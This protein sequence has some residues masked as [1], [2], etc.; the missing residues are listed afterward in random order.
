[1]NPLIKVQYDNGATIEYTFDAV[2]NRLT[3]QV[4]VFESTI[5]LAPLPFDPSPALSQETIRAATSAPAN[6]SPALGECFTIIT[7]VESPAEVE[8]VRQKLF[9]VI[10]QGGFSPEAKDHYK[11][12]FAWELQERE[13]TLRSEARESERK[14]AEKPESSVAT[15]PSNQ[16]QE[17]AAG[18]TRKNRIRKDQGTISNIPVDNEKKLDAG[19][20]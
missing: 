15:E 7:A 10:D 2:G 5:S 13:A 14:E 16:D 8:K 20:P 12:R 17:A 6:L 18:K 1:M 9:A 3:K 4:M 19:K 11:E